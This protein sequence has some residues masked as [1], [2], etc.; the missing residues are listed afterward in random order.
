M[1]PTV[2]VPL[3]VSPEVA[4]IKP[5]IVGVAVQVVPVTVRLPPKLV[6]LDPETVK[7]LSKV[8]APWRV[9]A[10]GVVVEPMVLIELE[11]EPKVLVRE[12]PVPK[13]VAPEEVKVVKL[14]A[15]PVIEPAPEMLPDES[16]AMVG[17]FKKLAYPVADSKLMPLVVFPA[18]LPPVP[19]GK[20]TTFKVLVSDEGAVLLVGVI[21]RPLEV[22]PAPELVKA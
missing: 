22:T 19:A 15:P 3:L 13:V 20:S 10:P 7:V 11:P 4:V 8:V 18:A 16:M 6:R 12:E 9:R 14:P 5:E 2:N 17:V 1:A 21:T